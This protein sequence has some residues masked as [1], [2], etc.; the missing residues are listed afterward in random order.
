MDLREYEQKKFALAEILRAVSHIV[1]EDQIEHRE[2]VRELFA[3]LAEDRFNLV[4]VGR[5]SRGK[6]SLMNAVLDTDRLPTGIAPLTSVITTVVYGSEERA[7]L[8]YENRVLD[9]KIA[10]EALPQ[11]ITQQGNPG[12]VQQ[13]R[14]AEVE[15][16]AEILR[17]G[18]CFVDTPGLGSVIVENTLTTEA[19][20]P[21]ADAFILVTSYDSPLSEEEMRFFKAGASSGRRIFVVLNKHDIVSTEDRSAVVTFV[22]HQLGRI[23]G[24]SVPQ[25]FSVS[26]LDGLEAARTGDA[27]RLA[28]SGIPEL[29]RRLVRFLL[30]EKRT[31]LLLRMCDRL[32]EL[33]SGMQDSDEIAQLNSQISALAGQSGQHD[34]TGSDEPVEN[35][36]AAFPDLHRMESCGICAFIAERLWDFLCR[37]QYDI[38]VNRAEQERFAE[39]GGFC[40]FHTWEYES[41]ASPYGICNGYPSLLDRLTAELRDAALSGDRGF[42]LRK[43]HHLLPT[44]DDCILC[45]VRDRAEREAV[46]RTVGSIE[47]DASRRSLSFSAMCLPHLVMVVGSVRDDR[48]ARELMKRQAAVLQRSSEDMRRYALK[49][50]ATRRH[51]ASREETTVANRGLLCVAGDRHANFPPRRAGAPR[52][53]RA[54]MAAAPSVDAA[55]DSRDIEHV[56]EKDSER[57]TGDEQAEI[58]P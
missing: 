44:E 27:A 33:L 39:L 19:F 29:K 24:R 46:A 43:L 54:P 14:T 8:K 3:R 12:N 49:H 57:R 45:G 48:V 22:A 28:A 15:L 9:R 50:D 11:Y 25:I 47:T 18:F 58:A 56:R 53:H 34:E 30:T 52:S 35:S 37:Y 40:P 7:I 41:I 36:T 10:I 4:V 5:F 13:I 51:L 42:V 26:S 32:R 31:E 1:P 6:T 16:P 38:A 21:A 55:G 17:R 23:F 20:V 2:R